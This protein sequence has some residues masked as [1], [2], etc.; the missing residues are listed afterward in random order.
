MQLRK[1]SSCIAFFYRGI[2][3]NLRECMLPRSKS[4]YLYT[5]SPFSNQRMGFVKD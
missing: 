3:R 4:A 5:Q 2:I 1:F